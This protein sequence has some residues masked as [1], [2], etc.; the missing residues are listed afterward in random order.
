M[1]EVQLSRK[2][3]GVKGEGKKQTWAFLSH[4]CAEQQLSVPNF[5]RILDSFT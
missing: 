4:H 2:E 3:G 1:E 5:V